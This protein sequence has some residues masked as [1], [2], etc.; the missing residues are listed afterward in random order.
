MIPGHLNKPSCPHLKSCS[1][2]NYSKLRYAL[3]SFKGARPINYS[4]YAQLID[5]LC[6]IKTHKI[7]SMTIYSSIICSFRSPN[8]PLI[9]LVTQLSHLIAGHPLLLFFPSTFPS[10][11]VFSRELGLLIICLKYDNLSLVI[12]ALSENFGWFVW[13]SICWFSCLTMV[14]SGVFF[15]TNVQ[16]YQYGSC[17][18]PSKSNMHVSFQI[19]FKFPF[20]QSHAN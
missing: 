10:S 18:V 1:F 14:L 13:W 20:T 19:S 15:N 2:L 7:F 6:A 11:G 5:W 8:S 16:R 17:P 4:I 12:F 3:G 9:F